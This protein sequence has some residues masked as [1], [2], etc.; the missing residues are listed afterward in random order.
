MRT[1]FIGGGNMAAA[2]IGGL[3]ARGTP[4]ADLR[5]VE[6]STP[7]RERMAT[8]APGV[9]LLPETTTEAVAGT[10]LVVLAV[11]P[12]NVRDAARRL[13]AHVADVPLVL[14]I[15]AGVRR[16]DIARWLGGYPRIV[17]AMPN[18]PALVGAGI[19]ALY[20]APDVRAIAGPAASVLEACGDVV[21][22]E[23]ERDLDAVTAVSGSGPAYVFYFLEA[24]ERAAVDLGLAPG[25]AR[26][27]AY[28]TFDGSM[29][30]AR[31]S[32][33]SP[34]ELR[35]KVTSKGGTTAR[36]IGVLDGAAVNLQFIAAVKAAAA[37]AAELGDENSNDRP[38]GD[39]P[40]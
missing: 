13:A 25:V 15:A 2:I 26:K 32:I 12:Q 14:T 5:V 38:E 3:L 28:A 20:A 29:R 19:S 4:A 30:L 6:P 36:A 17:R 40:C 11:K 27:L 9:Q 8:Q 37:R 16:A 21:W 1:T 23:R 31:Q 33:D 35:E 18:T 34:S 39:P 7:Q 22:C 24:L 10:D